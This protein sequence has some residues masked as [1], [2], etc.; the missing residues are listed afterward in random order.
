MT[1]TVFRVSLCVVMV[2]IVMNIFQMDV[3][4]LPVERGQIREKGKRH[5]VGSYLSTGKEEVVDLSMMVENTHILPVSPDYIAACIVEG[6]NINVMPKFTRLKPCGGD[7]S[8][9]IRPHIEGQSNT[10]EIVSSN[11]IFFGK[12]IFLSSHNAFLIVI[13]NHNVA[14]P[15]SLKFATWLSRIGPHNP[16]YWWNKYG[17]D[18]VFSDL[19]SVCRQFSQSFREYLPTS[20]AMIPQHYL[21]TASK[22]TE[23]ILSTS[24]QPSSCRELYSFEW[25]CEMQL[26]Q[27]S[28]TWDQSVLSKMCST[29]CSELFIV[30]IFIAINAI[31]FWLLYPNDTATTIVAP[32]SLSRMLLSMFSHWDI[33]HLSTNMY[34]L[35]AVGPVLNRQGLHCDTFQ[36]IIYILVSGV[37]GNIASLLWRYIRDD[38]SLTVGASGA[39]AGLNAAMCVLLP[40]TQNAH[41]LEVLVRYVFV[42]VIRS[43]CI[44]HN[45]DIAC[46]IGGAIGGYWLASWQLSGSIVNQHRYQ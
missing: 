1:L 34:S 20:V 39:I 35:L 5:V 41:P 45:I 13:E 14:F 22:M 38:Y 9:I 32:Y 43:V 44:G 17:I 6:S 19:Q 28:D 3:V 42:D 27:L 11:E 33:F 37:A 2:A 15:L 31:L 46:H 25:R 4:E 21:T 30:Y 29:I 10:D 40:H 18:I 23:Q 24:L 8:M 26:R 36:F 7:S 12:T 16:T